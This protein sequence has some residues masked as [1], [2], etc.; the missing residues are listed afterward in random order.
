MHITLCEA[1]KAVLSLISNFFQTT[2]YSRQIYTYVVNL[3]SILSPHNV[4]L[5]VNFEDFSLKLVSWCHF[6]DTRLVKVLVSFTLYPG[7]GGYYFMYCW[8]NEVLNK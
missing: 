1:Q 3:F 4:C 8:Y 6:S 7:Y 5:K 2:Y